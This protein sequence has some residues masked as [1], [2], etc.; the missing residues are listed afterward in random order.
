M[1]FFKAFLAIFLALAIAAPAQAQTVGRSSWTDVYQP[2]TPLTGATVTVTRPAGPALVN[3]NLAIKPATAIATLTT[4]LSG[5]FMNGDKLTISSSQSVRSLTITGGT[6]LDVPVSITAGGAFTYYYDASSTTWRPIGGKPGQTGLDDLYAP[7]NKSIAPVLVNCVGIGGDEQAFITAKSLSSSR[8]TAMLVGDGCISSNQWA[9]AGNSSASLYGIGGA[10]TDFNTISGSALPKSSYNTAGIAANAP[11]A[12]AIDMHGPH[13]F[14]V[15]NLNLFGDNIGN[16]QTLI[17]NSQ[18]NGSCCASNALVINN[19]S[20]GDSNG[21]IGCA[22]DGNLACIKAGGVWTVAL[23][24]GGSGYVDGTYNKVALTGGTGT[25]AFADYVVV[26]GG[27]VTKVA[28]SGATGAIVG[29]GAGSTPFLG[30]PG[31]NYVVGDVLSAN[32]SSLGGTGSGLQLTVGSITKATPT[33]ANVLPR[34]YMTQFS[35]TG[36]AMCLNASDEF[37][38]GAQF[39]GSTGVAIQPIF[40]GGGRIYGLGRFEFENYDIILGGP[41]ASSE[42]GASVI[43]GNTFDHLQSYDTNFRPGSEHRNIWLGNGKGYIVSSNMFYRGTPTDASI[44]VGGGTSPTLDVMINGDVWTSAFSASGITNAIQVKNSTGGVTP[45]YVYFGPIIANSGNITAPVLYTNVPTH[46]VEESIG[47]GGQHSERG[48]PWCIG[49]TSGYCNTAL[50]MD[51]TGADN[52]SKPLGLPTG[53]TAQRPTCNSTT[54]GGIRYNNTTNAVDSCQGGTPGWSSLVGATDT[55]TLTNKRINPR[56]TS[57]TSSATPTPNADTDD[58]YILT[59]LATGAAFAAPTGTPVQGQ[60]LII[61]IKDD[62]TARALSWN[63]AYRAVGALLP[64]TTTMSKVLYIA[65]IYNATDSKWDVVGVALE[66]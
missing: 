35:G 29:S 64:T 36:C 6:F 11:D 43:I 1:K 7:P 44:L 65:A 60:A 32:N 50:S 58:A 13:Q 59:A 40:G 56:V 63:A 54:L 38:I 14:I 15:N 39:S 4:A 37:V 57:V 25:N 33:T 8:V 23:T 55:Q 17:E 20:L 34:I 27:A 42:N 61:R 3:I 24:S 30:F 16:P 5:S 46:F 66:G 53:S 47:P 52:V 41:N 45:D 62:G 12:A 2:A 10:A 21:N 51:L 31:Q 49:Q 9:L 19:S 48:R 26:S 22:V 18:Q 28:L